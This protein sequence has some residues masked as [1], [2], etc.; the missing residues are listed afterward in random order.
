MSGSAFLPLRT[1]PSV[2]EQEGRLIETEATGAP[3]NTIATK[4]MDWQHHPTTLNYSNEF[5][6]FLL[7]LDI[8]ICPW[9]MEKKQL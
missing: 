9:V 7:L 6:C 4:S 8:F 1:T 3:Q 2:A 5:H